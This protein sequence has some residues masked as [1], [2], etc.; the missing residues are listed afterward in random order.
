[1]KPWLTE[2][3]VMVCLHELG[4]V[5]L[6]PSQTLVRVDGRRVLVEPDPERRPVKGCPNI[7][8]TIRPCRTTL[9]VREGYSALVRIDGQPICL[10]VLR[11]LTDGTPPGSI[12]YKV[13]D[14]GQVLV[15]DGA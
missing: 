12:D 14:A 5:R 9:V 2:D 13:R 15:G 4:R 6:E 8:P 3:A 10:D 1:M 11:G 7:G